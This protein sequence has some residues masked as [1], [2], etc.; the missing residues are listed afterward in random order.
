MVVRDN[1]RGI[2]PAQLKKLRAR[3][4]NGEEDPQ[5]IGM[6]NTQKRLQLQYGPEYGMKIESQAG[7]GTTVRLYLKAVKGG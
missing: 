4:K 6:V 1:G 2:P 3:L 5:H 7:K